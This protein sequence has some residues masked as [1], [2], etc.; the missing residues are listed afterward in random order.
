M[1]RSFFPLRQTSW[2]SIGGTNQRCLPPWDAPILT[3]VPAAEPQEDSYS[4]SKQQ[5]GAVALVDVVDRNQSGLN[6]LIRLQWLVDPGG[7]MQPSKGTMWTAVETGVE[8]S[9]C[10]GTHDQKR[11]APPTFSHLNWLPRQQPPH[12][13]ESPCAPR[14]P[15]SWTIVLPKEIAG[16]TGFVCPGVQFKVRCRERR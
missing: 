10:C 11:V 8:R 3:F 14:R 6:P 13:L 16:S 7:G 1:S 4:S 12:R 2:Q 9:D 5:R 15:I